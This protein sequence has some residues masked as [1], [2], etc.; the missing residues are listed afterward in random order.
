M[1]LCR[2]LL[3]ACMSWLATVVGSCALPTFVFATEADDQIVR[4]IDRILNLSWE[5]NGVVPAHVCTDLEFARRTSLDIVG[6]IP[7]LGAL[8]TLHRDSNPR[9]R[10][11]FVDELLASG[12]YSEYWSRVWV[13]LLLGGA[14]HRISRRS[15]L[16]HWVRSAFAFN[17]PYDRFVFELISAEGTSEMNPAVGFLGQPTGD[18]W[19]TV[20]RKVARVFLGM[21]VECTECHNHPY[22]DWKQSQFAGLNAFFQGTSMSRESLRGRGRLDELTDG[23]APAI[24]FFERRNGMLEATFRQF[25][26][27]TRVEPSPSEPDRPRRELAK[28]IIDPSRTYLAYAH[29][30]RMWQHFFGFGF[31]H[32]VDDMGPHNPASHPELLNLLANEFVRSGHDN[33]RLIRWITGSRAYQLSSQSSPGNRLDDPQSG[34]LPLFSRSYLRPL[35]S[36]QFLHSALM[37]IGAITDNKSWEFHTVGRGGGGCSGDE[38]MPKFTAVQIAAFRGAFD[39]DA[40]S[41]N[42]SACFTQNQAL[43]IMNGEVVSL[44]LNSATKTLI[45]PLLDEDPMHSITYRLL[46][47][48]HGSKLIQVTNRSTTRDRQRVKERSSSAQ[49][50]SRVEIIYLT[51]LARL[52]ADGELRYFNLSL[53]R[54]KSENGQRKALQDLLW[55]IL[56]S[57][58][59]MI[60]H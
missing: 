58:E 33:K 45:D 41:E 32:P 30:N 53:W 9:S 50:T 12:D 40:V 38:P 44:L 18:Q 4:E 7:R 3:I 11:N 42:L 26:D 35:T 15:A 48:L 22:N 60:N 28:L 34:R 31:S 21:Q 25:V 29:V 36:D 2:R 43:Q 54:D 46:V 1:S 10:E 13:H 57:N 59:F 37:G 27:G 6:H 16:S 52:P 23:P 20:T 56:N 47:P 14:E 51:F 17:K 5:Q 39:D 24:V 49:M 55:A 8:A 19:K